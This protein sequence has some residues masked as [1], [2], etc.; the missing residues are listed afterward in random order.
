MSD[1]YN[2]FFLNKRV[3]ITGHTGFKGS[4]LS[5]WLTKLGASVAGISLDPPTDPS[6]FDLLDLAH[7]TRWH[8]VEIQD[9][10]AVTDIVHVEEPEIVFHLA[11]QPLVPL[12]YEQPLLT[13]ST[14]VMGTVNI[15]EAAK[16]QSSIRSIVVVT[17][18]KCY[19]NKEW[20]WGY[21]E[22]DELGGYDP[23][24]SSKACAELVVKAY[25][26]SFF[27]PAEYGR[28]HRTRLATARAGNVIGG[29]DWARD[30]LIPD[31]FRALFSK[32]R[33]VL[34]NPG[35]IR[36]WQHVLDP[37]SGYL[38]LA[39]RLYLDEK[40]YSGAWN[41]GPA[42]DSA[43]TVEWV[44][45]QVREQ[46]GSPI[47]VETKNAEGYHEAGILTL[48]NAKATRLLSLSPNWKIEKTVRKTVEW[49]RAYFDRKDMM[50]LS[51]AQL[52]EFE[53]DRVNANI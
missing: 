3:L 17:T 21:R 53:K 23:Y 10:K 8:R 28:K 36:P 26:S 40:D 15:L 29:G 52:E 2:G 5:L 24:S 16:K 43:K 44:V 9:S 41:F 13:Y 33:I 20:P 1:I 30:R 34:R 46:W 19:E 27:N 31:I 51:L 14:N 35:A 42:P 22:C 50:N 4:W 7:V 39:K 18:D 25:R 12:S 11:A 6:L 49:Y 38:E 47:D 32:Q 45:S 48:D 37:L